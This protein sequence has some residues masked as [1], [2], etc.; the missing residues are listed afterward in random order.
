MTPRRIHVTGGQGSG[1]TTLAGRLHELTGAPVHELDLVARIGGGNGPERPAAERD[2]MV[3]EIAATED[4]ITEGVHLGW[5]AP[6]L[7]RADA[8][9]WLDNVS[10][11]EASGR[12]VRRFASGALREFRTRRGRQRFTRV[13]DYLRQTRGLAVSLRHSAAADDPDQFA[14]ALAAWPDTLVHCTSRSDV[15]AFVRAL[16][17]VPRAADQPG[18]AAS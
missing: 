11:I 13:G 7:D 6:L 8:I 3:R 5:T 17:P 12:M 18:D 10:S 14:T 9:V 16:T 2:A 1:K 4:W 15:E